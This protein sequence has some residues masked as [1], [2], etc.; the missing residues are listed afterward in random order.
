MTTV[1]E[2]ARRNSESV[3][4]I[5]RENPG[6]SA[7][8]I[9]LRLGLVDP[10]GAGC[11][12]GS[13]ARQVR[14]MIRVARQRGAPITIGIDGKGYYYLAADDVSDEQRAAM[15]RHHRA[16]TGAYLAGHAR[17]MQQIGQ[18]T[19][20][21]V[22]QLALFDILIPARDGDAQ[23]P[24]SMDDL[25]S[26]PVERRA[27]LFQLFQRYLEAMQRDPRAFAA[28]RAVVA[29]RFGKVFITREEAGKLA[30][31]KRLLEEV[32]I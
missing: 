28:E 29:D 24:A 14:E 27:G 25:A 5:I 13:A 7:S 12:R 6:L 22:A 3:A 2:D 21:E 31:A 9:G 20:V 19:G 32:G 11:S 26:L 17:L 8:Q 10:S 18:M 4:R 1:T 16:R 15:V 30:Q 23:R